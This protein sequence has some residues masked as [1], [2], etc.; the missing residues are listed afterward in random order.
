MNYRKWENRNLYSAYKRTFTKKTTSFVIDCHI[1]HS[2]LL[3]PYGVIA[4]CM[5]RAKDGDYI[6]KNFVHPNNGFSLIKMN[7]LG[8][9]SCDE[10]VQIIR[11]KT[12]STGTEQKSSATNYG[13]VALHF[14]PRTQAVY[15]SIVCSDPF[16]LKSNRLWR[17]AGPL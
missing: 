15:N 8:I 1:Y 4:N 2:S 13:S 5:I 14:S 9:S 3:N 16:G 10:S 17:G 6:M 12:G 11:C 7:D